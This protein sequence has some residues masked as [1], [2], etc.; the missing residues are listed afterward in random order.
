LVGQLAFAVADTN[1]FWEDVV[2]SARAWGD[3]ATL[4]TE[5]R[6]GIACVKRLRDAG[7]EIPAEE[8]ET[9]ASQFRGARG[10]FTAAETTAWLRERGLTAENWIKY[11]RRSWL[12]Q[13]WS[14]ELADLVCRYPAT[15][16]QLNRAF[17]VVGICSGH[18]ARFAEKL[19]GR[20]A[21]GQTFLSAQDT[22]PKRQRG[23]GP[24]AGATGLCPAVDTQACGFLRLAPKHCRKVLES[25]AS[26]E[27]SYS[28]FGRQVL[29][30]QALQ[31]QIASRHTVWVRLECRTASFACAS[32]AR[33]AALCV[34]EDG[35]E[36]ATVAA[37][38]GTT[39]H[40]ERFYLE[41]LEPA[42]Q[43]PFLS[44]RKGELLGPLEWRGAFQLV[45]VRD[46][47]LPSAED[48]DIRRRAEQL[49]L[50]REVEREI[51][52]R[53]QWHHRL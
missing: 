3:W 48:P 14:A 30:P 50:Q 44:A 42:Q 52:D 49:L 41:E 29:T 13:R 7:G 11:I 36:L 10:L 45:Q 33:E 2:L 31:S 17:L 26:L 28:L 21:V 38:A 4:D 19:A 39:L 51:K 25:L 37:R 40:Q 1:Y 15:E 43:A 16:A 32:A 22:S 20:A 6:Q 47:V 53:V 35:E 8:V 18:L 27:A 5:V 34:R 12:R 9:A 46:K 24:V 23:D